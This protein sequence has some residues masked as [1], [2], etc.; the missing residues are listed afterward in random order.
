MRSRLGVIYAKV[1]ST[2]GTDSVP[3]GASNAL[4]AHDVKLDPDHGSNERP[5]LGVTKSRLKEIG[6]RRKYKLSFYVHLRGSGAAGTAPRGIGDLLKA[7][8]LTET[9]SA[10]V[11]V[12]YAPRSGSLQSCTVYLYID[13]VRHILTGCVGDFEIAGKAGEIGMIK[14]TFSC[15]YATPSDQALPSSPTYDSTV[16]VA[17]KNLTATLDAYAAVI[18]EFSLKINNKITERGDFNATHGIRGF[19]ITDR[20][21]SG[22]LTVEAT[23]LAT[24]NWYTKFEADTVQVLSIAIG[25]SAGNIC[26]ISANQCRL[27]NV[28][29]DDEDGLLVH[30]LPFQMSRSSVDDE[31]S[32]VFT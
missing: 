5:D 1:E 15:L 8:D 26:T 14:F 17:L 10:G 24:K 18:R 12:T 32:V 3:T 20:N 22:E 30:K 29:Y 27:R 25:V 21:P 16:P 7:S 23:A 28:P 19:D 6:G 13:G 11:S 2:Y 31:L 9:I 4:I